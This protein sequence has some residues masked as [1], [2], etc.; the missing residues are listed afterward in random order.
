MLKITAVKKGSPAFK[1]GI[2]KGDKIISVNGKKVS[3]ELDFQFYT[4]SDD[5]KILISSKNIDRE[6]LFS[7]SKPVGIVVEGMK[8]RHCGNKCIFCF[9]DQNPPGLRKTLYVKDE[10][11]RYSFL[12]GNYFTLTNIKQQELDKIVEMKLTP[13]YISVH[14]ADPAARKKLLGVSRDDGLINKIKYLTERGI[15]L[16]AQIVLCP[17]INDGKVLKE[18]IEIMSGLYPGV[19][20]LAVV[21]VGLT[22]HR[23]KLTHLR[24]VSSKKSAEVVSLINSFSSSFKKKF[25]TGFVFAAD[26]FYLKAGVEI[27]SEDHYE[28]YQQF[29][30]GIGMTRNFIERFKES[31]TDI[32]ESVDPGIRIK[33]ITGELFFPVISSLVLRYFKNVKNLQT[34]VVKVSNSLFGYPVSVAGLLSG[35][36]IAAAAGR[37]VS[38]EDILLIPPAC[39]NSDGLFLDD[40]NIQELS[41]KTGYNVFKFE[42]P[43]DIFKNLS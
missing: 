8:V 2:I 20:S 39:L 6:V 43:V 18:T 36:D 28:S 30:N 33:L 11:Y 42:N 10:D 13:L 23:D 9:I 14:A 21:P 29:E 5:I 19:A 7:G 26:E 34:E 37:A 35:S 22:A 38:P 24:T 3:D 16:H 25:G 32:P 40:M 4:A 15:E 12:Y 17:G 1:A 31:I 41:A 27:P